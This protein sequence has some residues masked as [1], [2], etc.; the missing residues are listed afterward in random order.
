M[1]KIYYQFLQYILVGG[2]AFVV[3]FA[4]LYVLTEQAGFRY[5]ISA[6]AGFLLGL[7]TNYL[8]CVTWIFDAHALKNRLHEFIIFGLIGI[9]GLG[10][11]DLSIIILTETAK[12]H[13]LVSKLLAAV[14][15]LIF[16]F[17]LR[18]WFLFSPS[19]TKPYC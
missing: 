12:F 14:L 7:A 6:S 11:N 5:L 10:L 9:V 4:T 16:N 2:T 15:I 1:Q 19:E 13:Y 18:R 8:L 3:D 17:S